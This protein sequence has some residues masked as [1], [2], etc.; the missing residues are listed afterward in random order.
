MASLTERAID[1]L[2]SG[3]WNLAHKIV[4]SDS[5]AEAAWIHAHLHCIEGDLDNA[6]YWYARAG[7]EPAAGSIE[8]ERAAIVDALGARG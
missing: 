1:A 4:Q 7:R 3:D 8:E 6:H 5:S 2:Q